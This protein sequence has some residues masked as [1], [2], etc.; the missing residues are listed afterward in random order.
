MVWSRRGDRWQHEFLHGDTVVLASVEGAANDAFPP[1]PAY[2]EM[3][4]E[5]VAEGVTEYQLMGQSGKTIYSASVRVSEGT[6]LIE[7][8]CCAR[9]KV[10]AADSS[11][12]ATYQVSGPANLHVAGPGKPIWRGEG[13]AVWLETVAPR[14][15]GLEARQGNGLWSVGWHAPR[16]IDRVR[17]S[18]FR[19]MYRLRVGRDESV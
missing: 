2:Q 16:G 5:P 6:Q 8:D 12:I 11:A 15:E 19:W 10:E 17:G 1:S 13:V 3:L 4:V 9:I 14:P 18:S 7:F